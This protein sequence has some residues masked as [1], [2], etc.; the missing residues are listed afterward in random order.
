LL[1][2]SGEAGLSPI[3]HTRWV[4]LRSTDY[5]SKESPISTRREVLAARF[6]VSE[7]GDG[8]SSTPPSY[9]PSARDFDADY[10]RGLYEVGLSVQLLVLG[11]EADVDPYQLLDFFLGL[12]TLDVAEDDAAGP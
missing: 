5:A 8:R 4:E 3:Y 10:D 1:T 11:L 2:L 12:F 9:I 7:Q 6:F